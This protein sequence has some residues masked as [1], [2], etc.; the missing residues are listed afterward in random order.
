MPFGNPPSYKVDM[1]TIKNLKMCI[2]ISIHIY[3]NV[4]AFIFRFFL[5][6]RTAAP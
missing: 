3:I 2:D 5:Q 6:Q 1:S 4:C